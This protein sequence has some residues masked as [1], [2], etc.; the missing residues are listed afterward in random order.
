MNKIIQWIHG[1]NNNIPSIILDFEILNDSIYIRFFNASLKELYDVRVEFSETLLG[2]RG[3]KI[4]SELNV[5]KNL[6]YMAPNKE[7]LIYVDEIDSF[8]ANLKNETI[9]I[10]I[11]FVL[12]NRKKVRKKTVH[13]LS[14]YKDLILINKNY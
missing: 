13:N 6:R 14:I 11:T 1:L 3:D 9:S 7:F 4:I 12:S 5:F 10:S 8:Y 2:L